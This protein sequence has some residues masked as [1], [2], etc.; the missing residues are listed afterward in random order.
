M[1]GRCIP[2]I[3]RTVEAL[4]TADKYNVSTPANWVNGNPVIQSNPQTFNELEQRMNEI[5]KE[6]NGMSW[7]L[8]FTNVEE[9][10]NRSE[11]KKNDKK[12]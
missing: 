10:N 6:R 7:Y 4:Q 1:F 8:S 9:S 2:E 3:L 5:E 12:L 11:T